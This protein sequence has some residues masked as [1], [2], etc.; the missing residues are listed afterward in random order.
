MLLQTWHDAVFVTRRLGIRYLWVHS[1]CI[2]QDDE[3]DWERE[4]ALM[5]PFMPVPMILSQPLRPLIA[6]R[7]SLGIERLPSVQTSTLLLLLISH[8]QMR[9]I[10][11]HDQTA[12]RQKHT[13]FS[14]AKPYHFKSCFP[15]HHYSRGPGPFKKP[16][17]PGAWRISSP[18][19]SS[20]S[21][22]PACSLRTLLSTALAATAHSSPISVSTSLDIRQSWRSWITDY[23]RRRLSK[24]GDKMAA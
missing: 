13:A 5:H 18:C 22:G 14:S 17:Y 24:K 1:L 2:I 21:A 23:S 8:G 7:A 4:P 15:N 19:N 12:Q 6:P 9:Q 16:S 11:Y 20:G 3:F 10:Q